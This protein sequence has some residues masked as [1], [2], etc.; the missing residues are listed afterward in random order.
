[1]F[2]FIELMWWEFAVFE[3]FAFIWHILIKIMQMQKLV[4]GIQLF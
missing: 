3:N 1:M 2:S 4:K